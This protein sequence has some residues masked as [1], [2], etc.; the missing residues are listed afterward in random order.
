MTDFTLPQ[1][2]AIAMASARARMS[3]AQQ[4]P[5]GQD[6]GATSAFINGANEM[7]PF[8]GKL[9]SAM[10]AGI[11]SL[12][13]A[14]DYSD[15]YQQAQQNAQAT[16]QANP[17]ASLAGAGTGLAATLP[18]GIEKTIFGKVPT[19]G[20]RGVIN[21]IPEAVAKVRNWTSGGEVAKDAGLLAKSGNLALQSAKSAVVAAPIGAAYGAGSAEQGKMLEGAIGGAGGAA[22]LSA[23]IPLVGAAASGTLNAVL[24]KIEG[25]TAALAQRAKDFGID[26]RLDQVSPTRARKTIQKVSQEL[27]FSGVDA[28]ESAQ[29]Q[30]FTQ[31]VAKTIG[32]DAQDLS[33]ETINKF[34]DDTSAKYN[35]ILK[36]QMIYI[37]K[38]SKEKL[39]KLSSEAS[40]T[41]TKDLADVVD[42]NINEL[43]SNTTDAQSIRGEVVS[44]FRSQLTQRIKNADP[45]VK[46]YLGDIIEAI[47]GMVEET[48]PNK[49]NDLKQVRREWRNFKTIEPLLEKSTDGT[50]NP[51]ELLNRVKANPYIKASRS[52]LGQDDLVDL[53]RIGKQFL[54][55]SGGSDTVQK[56]ILTGGIGGLGVTALNNP[57]LAISAGVKAGAGLALNRGL[58]EVNK[59][60]TLVGLAVKGAG[61]ARKKLN[62]PVPTSLLSGLSGNSQ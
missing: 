35:S 51:T 57:L 34:L 59:S 55:K 60:K 33:P 21:Q 49:A 62:S 26:L 39:D 12:G 2:Q 13:G 1:R 29:R 25:K 38:E 48:L 3:V 22:A 4:E 52:S 16:A 8:G 27:P 31:A 24:P 14:G 36:D 61:K 28:S 5:Q 17:V 20:V 46:K 23:A 54:A 56:G 45:G 30:Q 7:V 53:A 10:G 18:I 41:L 58:Q 42:K 11:A 15:L 50:I 40:K 47:D 32:Q 44:N 43:I 37:G 9:T 6:A 19:S